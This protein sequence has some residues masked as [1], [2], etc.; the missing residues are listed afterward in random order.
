[1]DLTDGSSRNGSKH[2]TV[3]LELTFD[4]LSLC[5]PHTDLEDEDFK[6]VSADQVG[7]VRFQLL[8]LDTLTLHLITNLQRHN[9]PFMAEI[10]ST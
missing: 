9:R 7:V 4:L 6:V 10:K 1:M 3:G 2:F 5:F 8:H